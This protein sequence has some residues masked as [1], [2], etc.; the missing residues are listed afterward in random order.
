MFRRTVVRV[1]GRTRADAQPML[2]KYILAALAAVFLIAATIRGP[3]TPQGRTWL[4]IAT[5]FGIVSV[6][7][8]A[9]G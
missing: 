3:R 7:L 8:F 6:W 9:R 1:H 2:A 5:I 4:L